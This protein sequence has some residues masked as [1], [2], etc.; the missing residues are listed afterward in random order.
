MKILQ[1]SF[2]GIMQR[3]SGTYVLRRRLYVFMVERMSLEVSVRLDQ[4][5]ALR[6][7]TAGVISQ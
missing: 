5:W 3:L 1:E 7:S 4:S 6:S 2:Y